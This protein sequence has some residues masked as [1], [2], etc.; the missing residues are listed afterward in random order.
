MEHH[1]LAF[2]LGAESGRA[3]LGSL[4]ASDRLRIREVHRFPNGPVEIGGRLHW[5]V[6]RLT[7]EIFEG[8]RLCA[9]HHTRTLE[10]VGVD[11]W[12]VDFALLDERGELAGAP[13]AYRDRRFPDAMAAFFETFPRD[14]LYGLT[15][16]QSLPFNT[17]FQLHALV[18]DESPLLERATDLLF[19]PD[20]FARLL[21]G[22][23]VSEFTIASTSQLVDPF[24]RTWSEEILEHLRL[25]KGLLQEIV[26]PGTVLGPLLPGDVTE[27][28]LARADVVLPASHDTGSAVAAVPAAGTDFAYISCGTWSLMGIE[29]PEPLIDERTSAYDFTNE[30]GVGGT[31]RVLKNIMGLWILQACRKAWSGVSDLSWDRLIRGAEG[32]PSFQAIIDPDHHSFLHPPDMPAALEA[33][34]RRTGQVFPG[35]RGG[36]VRMVI[37]SLALAYRHTLDQIEAIRGERIESIH[38]IGGGAKNA[39][40]CRFTADATARPVIAGPSEATA[41]GNVLVQAMAAGRIPSLEALRAV[42]RNAFKPRVFEP[43]DSEAWEKPYERFRE[44]K[45]SSL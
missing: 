34:C 27:T 24:E 29:S 42:V 20:L 1:Y 45:K 38:L 25:P 30:G 44:L 19:M 41:V 21:S 15:G 37:E 3:I 7:G 8:L 28:G 5:D 9:A 39:L 32:A 23:S 43:E 2:D 36:Q 10:S 14:R 13:F 4:D 17:L 11:T 33:Y 18:R 22:K 31:F 35:E 26:S 12:G 40:L 6:P 16:I